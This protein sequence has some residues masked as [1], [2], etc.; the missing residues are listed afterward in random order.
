MNR[1]GSRHAWV[2]R[3]LEHLVVIKGLSENSVSA[4]ST[5]L[6]DF[7]D[8]L[9]ERDGSLESAEE[10]TLF[11]YLVSLRSRGLTS[12]SLARRISS[13]RTFFDYAAHEGWFTHNPARLL[14]GP[15]IQKLLPRVL[16]IED[17]DRLLRQPDCTTKLG[18]RDRAILETMYAAGLRVSEICALRPLDFDAQAGILRVWGKG[19]KERFVPMHLSAQKYLETYLESWRPRFSPKQDAAFLNRSGTALTRQGLWKMIKRYALQAGIRQSISPHS[20]RHS[21]ATHLLEGGADLRT[22]QVLL[23]HADISATEIYTHVQ[24]KRLLDIHQA[25][26]PRS[27]MPTEDV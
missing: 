15:K 4:Y 21:F 22:L 12:R 16:S 5:D 2:D 13:L 1:D 20:I 7:L 27:H 6:H 26:H 8:F 14:D 24:G 18:F 10:Q 9:A 23:G 3:Y 25:H 17:M 19:A 11:L